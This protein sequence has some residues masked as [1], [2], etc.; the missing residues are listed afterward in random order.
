MEWRNT[1]VSEKTAKKEKIDPQAF[2]FTFLQS[3]LFL[4][5]WLANCI[6]LVF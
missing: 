1:E 4:T 2:A 5:D 3:L 6:S